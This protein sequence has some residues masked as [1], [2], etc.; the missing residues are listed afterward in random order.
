MEKKIH[1]VLFTLKSPQ[2]RRPGLSLILSLTENDWLA[3][4]M[5]VLPL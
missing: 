4:V 5:E 3:P 1:I 2:N